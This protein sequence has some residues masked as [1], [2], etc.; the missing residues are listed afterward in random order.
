MRRRDAMDAKQSLVSLRDGH[1]DRVARSHVRSRARDGIQTTSAL[2][3]SR[4]CVAPSEI[5]VCGTGSP[6]WDRE[7]FELWSV[8]V[9]P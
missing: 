7:G 5:G 9:L 6:G 3:A 4:L 8:G 2:R 1:C